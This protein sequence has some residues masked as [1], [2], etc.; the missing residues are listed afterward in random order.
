MKYLL[1]H[2]YRKYNF[3]HNF[4]TYEYIK[5]VGDDIY[6]NDNIILNLK[7]IKFKK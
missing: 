4:R 6:W 5:F 3:P 1:E 2:M 7:N